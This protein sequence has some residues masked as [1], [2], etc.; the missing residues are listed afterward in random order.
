[1]SAEVPRYF[2]K[3]GYIFVTDK[4][5]LL[6]TVLG[7]C[8][9][10][11]L[12]DKKTQI[13]SMNH[14]VFDKPYN[15]QRDARFAS[16]SIPYMIRLM[17]NRGSRLEDVTAHIVGGAYNSSF[18]NLSVSENNISTT[19]KILNKFKLEIQT[20][21]VGGEMGRKVIFNTET[22]EILIYKVNNVRKDDWY[23]YH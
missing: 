15:N 9:S 20:R 23:D 22:G 2:V 3:P 10:V 13:A 19:E 21:D 12:R 8:V 6:H 1:M 11:C 7:S 14:I 5:Y 17:K 16:I 4:P 18:G